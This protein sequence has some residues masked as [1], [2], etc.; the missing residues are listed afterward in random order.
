MMYA[1]YL[2]EYSLEPPCDQHN[3]RKRPVDT[4]NIAD[5]NQTISNILLGCFIFSALLNIIIILKHFRCKVR[6]ILF[7]VCLLKYVEI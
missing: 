4:E 5:E 2:D 6:Q 1:L 3:H 7:S